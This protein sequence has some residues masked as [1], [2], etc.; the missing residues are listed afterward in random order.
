M[1]KMHYVG[2]HN[3]S[4]FY[5]ETYPVILHWKILFKNILNIEM[6]LLYK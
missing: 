3:R 4:D 2:L 1:L 6:I 5:F